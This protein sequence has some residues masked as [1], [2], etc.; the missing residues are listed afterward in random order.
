MEFSEFQKKEICATITSLY[1]LSKE[2]HKNELQ[3]ISVILLRAIKN[4]DDYIETKK[5]TELSNSNEDIFEVIEY[6]ENLMNIR[7]KESIN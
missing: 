5:Q 4:I 1:F 6:F 7:P 3:E 2:A